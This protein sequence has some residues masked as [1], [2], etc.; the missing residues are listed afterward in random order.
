MGLY[1]WRVNNIKKRRAINYHD[2]YG[3]SLLCLGLVAAVAVSFVFRLSKGG[4]GGLKG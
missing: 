3:P 4:E 1:L 2:K